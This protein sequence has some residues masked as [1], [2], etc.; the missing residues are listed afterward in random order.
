LCLQGSWGL[1]DPI[2]ARHLAVCLFLVVKW[3]GPIVLPLIL[4]APPLPPPAWG[5]SD[6]DIFR[7]DAQR[8]IWGREAAAAACNME[9]EEEH[10]GWCCMLPSRGAKY[11]NTY[12]NIILNLC[13]NGVFS[14]SKFIDMSV[15]SGLFCRWSFVCAKAIHIRN[16]PLIYYYSAA[17]CSQ[18]KIPC[19]S[20]VNVGEESWFPME[21]D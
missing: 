9:E 8:R 14:H 17:E 7:A 4:L 12:S 18:Q 6:Y 19:D 1:D 13:G 5:C 10:K 3:K 11:K 15:N 16:E 20:N 21:V 2:F